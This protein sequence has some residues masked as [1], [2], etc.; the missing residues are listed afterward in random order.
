M[1]V[2]PGTEPPQI[3]TP[4]AIETDGFVERKLTFYS[5]TG[6]HIDA[7]AHIMP[8]APTLDRLP[9]ET[10][11][12]RGSVIDL[13]FISVPEIGLSFIEPFEHLFKTS[14]FIL[15]HSGWDRYWG[16]ENYFSDYPVLS[17]EAALWIRSFNLKGIG[18]DMI[19]VDETDTTT[20]AI[21]KILLERGIIIENLTGL[22]RL[23]QT[24][25]TFSCFP[26]KLSDADGSPVRAVGLV[27]SEG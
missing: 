10:F 12:G 2:Y 25:F 18:I 8:H 1:P 27:K 23:P 5:H 9:I 15:F 3:D 14:D 13:T 20:Y 6:T 24:G 11:I 4:C 22:R 17:V 7:P 19:S 16:Q 21:H 26:L